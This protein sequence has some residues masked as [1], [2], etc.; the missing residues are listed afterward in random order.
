MTNDSKGH[1]IAAAT[2]M[3]GDIAGTGINRIS[4]GAQISRGVAFGRRKGFNEET[5]SECIML[6]KKTEANIKRSSL[7]RITLLNTCE[8]FLEPRF[9]VDRL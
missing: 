3:V 7:G 9:P 5:R 4:S 6:V 8:I 2:G 1:R